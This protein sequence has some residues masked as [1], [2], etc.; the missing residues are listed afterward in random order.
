MTYYQT[1]FENLFYRVEEI[2]IFEIICL[3][4]LNY[5]LKYPTLYDYIELFLANGII[6]IDDFK[7]N[8]FKEIKLYARV[9]E[10]LNEIIEFTIDSKF[11]IK[12][13]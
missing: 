6:F 10:F 2:R 1:I 13:I 11:C 8:N 4:T 9:Y 3:K 7:E 5:N 12:I